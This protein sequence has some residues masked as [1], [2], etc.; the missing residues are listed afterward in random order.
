MNEKSVVE[1]FYRT[2][3]Q[4]LGCEDHSDKMFPFGRR[5][6]WNNRKP[7]AGRFPGH[8]LVRYHGPAMIHVHLTTPPV[9][10]LFHSIDDVLAAI[11]QVC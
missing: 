6:R 5:T 11:R 10:G 4:L 2:V 1:D 8:G 7:G 3:A 9:Q